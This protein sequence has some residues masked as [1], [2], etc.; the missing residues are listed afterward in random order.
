MG[1]EVNPKSAL[2]TTCLQLQ[3]KIREMGLLHMGS[4]KVKI[5]VVWLTDRQ[6]DV[7]SVPPLNQSR[8]INGKISTYQKSLIENL[9]LV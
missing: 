1:Q 6:T 4:S 5:K 9:T 7:N 2:V 3:C 8:S